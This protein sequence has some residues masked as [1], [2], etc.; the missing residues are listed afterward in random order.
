MNYKFYIQESPFCRKRF[1]KIALRSQSQCYM[2]QFIS[3]PG[4]RERHVFRS[5]QFNYIAENNERK[6]TRRETWHEYESL[7]ISSCF[8][9]LP[10][11]AYVTRVGIKIKPRRCFRYD[12]EN[13]QVYRAILLIS[14]TLE[15]NSRLVNLSMELWFAYLSHRWRRKPEVDDRN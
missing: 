10:R 14:V 11:C 12:V 8:L 5:W 7:W 13:F 15:R 2:K 4:K 3:L 6:M 9:S 1:M